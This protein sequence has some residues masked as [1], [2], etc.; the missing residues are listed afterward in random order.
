MRA[1]SLKMPPKE[2][3]NKEKIA[4]FFLRAPQVPGPPGN[5]PGYP[6]LDGPVIEHIFWM[7]KV[8]KMKL[9]NHF[10]LSMICCSF[11]VCKFL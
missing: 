3:C 8:I 9:N 5:Y 7:Q 1:A 2:N 10:A 6:P 11:G 4:Y